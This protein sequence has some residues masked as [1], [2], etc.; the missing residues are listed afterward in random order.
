MRYKGVLLDLDNT[1]YPYEPCNTAGIPAVLVVLVRACEKKE[2]QLLQHYTAARERIKQYAVPGSLHSRFLYLQHTIEMLLGKTDSALLQKS[3]DAFWRAYFNA[4][5]LHEQAEDFLDF[6]TKQ[7]VDIIIVSDFEAEL[8]HKKILH[9]GIERFIRFVV[10]SGEVGAEKPH[11]FIFHEA[12]KKARLLPTEVVM[13]GDD[14]ERDIKGARAA[15]ID[16]L[17]FTSFS[18]LMSELQNKV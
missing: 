17:L 2:N 11:P 8:Q 3:H 5:Q 4:M 13:I 16:A 9:L 1:L 6:L 12:L 15:G 18:E 14:E 7:G 10:T